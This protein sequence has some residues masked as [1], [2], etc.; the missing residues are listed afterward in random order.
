M[1]G[2]ELLN[3]FCVAFNSI[4]ESKRLLKKKKFF[5]SSENSF[6]IDMNKKKEGRKEKKGGLSFKQIWVVF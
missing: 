2:M 4:G 5:A 3:Q 6:S 1:Q